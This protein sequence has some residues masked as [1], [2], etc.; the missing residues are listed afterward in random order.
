MKTL[1]QLLKPLL[2]PQVL[3][4]THG[5]RKEHTEELAHELRTARPCTEDRYAARVICRHS[6]DNRCPH[7]TISQHRQ[8]GVGAVTGPRPEPDTRLAEFKCLRSMFQDC[9]VPCGKNCRPG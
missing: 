8:P 2:V 7:R 5:V 1:A 9:R 3:L 4:C 6:T